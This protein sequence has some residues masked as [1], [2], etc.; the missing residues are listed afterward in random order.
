[1]NTCSRTLEK[2]RRQEKRLSC[3]SKDYSA[4][5][6]GVLSKHN[7]SCLKQM[8]VTFSGPTCADKTAELPS[9][10]NLSLKSKQGCSSLS[11]EM[12]TGRNMCSIKSPPGLCS[13]MPSVWLLLNQLFGQDTYLNQCRH[14]FKRLIAKK[15]G[16]KSL[17]DFFTVHYSSYAISEHVCSN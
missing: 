8:Q 12:L 17:E 7:V 14:L 9:V 10:L 15:T 3:E 11:K 2:S 6:A 4:M 16:K 5:P 1:M 13:L